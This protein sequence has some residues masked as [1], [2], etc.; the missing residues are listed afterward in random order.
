[1]T[2]MNDRPQKENRE[3][4]FDYWA[5]VYDR[6]V[7]DAEGFPFDGYGRV[8]DTVVALAGVWPGTCV[9]DLGSG[10]GNLSA[11]FVAA[12]CEVWGVDFSSAMISEAKK[13]VPDARFV[14]ANVLESWPDELPQRFGRIVSA[15]VLHEFDLTTKVT[16]LQK[17]AQRLTPD[18]RIVVG[19]VAFPTV[20]AREQARERWRDRWD[21]DEHY[22]AAD[23]AEAAG[24]PAGLGL[25]YRQ[26]S[27]CG[28]VFV[29]GRVR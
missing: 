28:G 18:G 7:G 19:D 22:W 17:L 9:L 29:M 13:K 24:W 11:R 1:M 27:G 15:Y 6:S 2:P 21:P 26:V 14:R 10:T 8:L 4:L 20:E 3:R 25:E 16:M 5:A 23:E 12:G